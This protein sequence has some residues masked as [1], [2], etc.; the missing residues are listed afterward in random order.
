M[1]FRFENTSL[2]D[3]Q[4]AEADV[5]PDERGHLLES[6]DR[7]SF[8]AAGIDGEFVLDFYSRSHENVIRGLHVQCDPAAQAKLVHVIQG[9]IFDV[10]VDLRQGSDTFGE[11]LTRRLTGE[12]KEILYVPEGFAHGYLVQ[13]DD[14][15]V[16]YKATAPFTPEHVSGV[17]WDDPELDIDWPLEG[18]PVL[19]DQDEE[20]PPLDAWREDQPD[21]V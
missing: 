14:T 6:Y 11:Y 15:I 5:F 18:E 9:T 13:S 1:P 16:Q 19:S 8:T 10:V 21:P 12:E 4:V 3:V 7:A 17:A 20:L 2:P